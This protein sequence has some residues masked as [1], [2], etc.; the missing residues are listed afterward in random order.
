[1]KV[2]LGVGG[3]DDSLR[4]LERTIDRAIAAGDDL[5]VAVVENPDSELTPDELETRVRDALAEADLD[6]AVRRVEGDPGSRL[7][8]LAEAESFDQIVL[9]GGQTSPMG[10]INIGSIAEFVLLNSTKTVTLIR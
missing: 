5:T 8:D 6:A 10:K 3:S 2:L 9:G 4:A 1:M 7:V